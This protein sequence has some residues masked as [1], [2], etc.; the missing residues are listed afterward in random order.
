MTQT[1][2]KN[3]MRDCDHKL[4]KLRQAPAGEWTKEMEDNVIMARSFLAAAILSMSNVKY[5]KEELEPEEVE[6]TEVEG[7]F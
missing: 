5:Q 1:K 2:R 6:D 4:T 7:L 3:I